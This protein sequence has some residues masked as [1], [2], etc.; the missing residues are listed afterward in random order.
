[1]HGALASARFVHG[2]PR[3]SLL[4]Y[5][6]TWPPF[7]RP[8]RGQGGVGSSARYLGAAHRTLCAKTLVAVLDRSPSPRVASAASISKAPFGAA[9]LRG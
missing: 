3:T 6:P 9:H 1:M 7:G 2:A 4:C 8:E 5:Y